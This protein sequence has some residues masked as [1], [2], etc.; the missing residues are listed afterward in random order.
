MQEPSRMRSS[1]M[2]RNKAQHLLEKK[3]GLSFFPFQNSP[4]DQ[5]YNK[6]FFSYKLNDNLF[7]YRLK[8][9]VDPQI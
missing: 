6:E 3:S 5:E 4:H 9:N 2:R 8:K 7:L 1:N